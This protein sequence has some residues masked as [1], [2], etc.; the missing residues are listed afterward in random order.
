MLSYGRTAVSQESLTGNDANVA[1]AYSLMALNGKTQVW[2]KFAHQELD[3]LLAFL[4]VPQGTKVVD[5]GCGTG[6]HAI[7]LARRG[8]SVRA[9]DYVNS[10]VERVK[11]L[12]VENA[13]QIGQAGGA[14]AVAWADARNLPPIEAAPLVLCLYDVVGSSPEVE[15][16]QNLIDGLF[17][18]CTPGG[19]AAIGCMNGM[20][21]LRSIS[22]SRFT[23]REPTLGELEPVNT[24]QKS[25]EV[26]DFSKMLFDPTNGILYRREQFYDEGRI[27]HDCIL[28]ERRF[29]PAEI[30]HM[31]HKTG[32][33]NVRCTSVRAGKWDFSATFDPDAPEL[34]FTC[35][36][37]ED[38]IASMPRIRP[39]KST[40]PSDRGYNLEVIPQKNI[41][42][43]HAAIVSRIFCTS[44]GR[45]P[46]TGR[47]HIL[48]PARQFERLRRCSYLCLTMKGT[49]PVGY[50]FGTEY[51]E[52]H[53]TIAW[54][55][56]ICVIKE[57]R[58]RGLATAMLDAFARAV[59]QFEWLGA[60]SPN[61][62]TKLVLEKLHLGKIFGPGEPAPQRI[63]DS[64]KYIKHACE[65]LRNCEIDA[66][67]M[68]IKTKFSVDMDA[69]EREWST[70]S[71]HIA[72]RRPAW[73]TQLANLPEDYESLLIIHRESRDAIENRGLAVE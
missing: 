18:V 17:R 30:T 27:N 2:A 43:Q 26:F 45:N 1:K 20:Q 57:F 38:T 29:S 52:L 44:F 23:S 16:A 46:K 71:G 24:M 62:I 67:K 54:L 50:M 31:L 40:Q 66:G 37:P 55:D 15:D 61:P 28:K 22:P 63:I 6:R 72:S 21:M 14:L 3:S 64:L 51:N 8:Y 65:D 4:G 11:N 58:R 19:S 13:D 56:S 53:T 73:W 41:T 47:P 36:R 69:Q 39:A 42:A 49:I 70:E 5:V 32:F 7:D 25:G 10:W 34:L 9:F 48:G 35:L 33:I 68:L 12:A 59:P 60:T